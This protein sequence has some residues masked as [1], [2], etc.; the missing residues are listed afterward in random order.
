[1]SLYIKETGSNLNE[2][3]ESIFSQTVMPDEIVVVKD[4]PLSE[5]VEDVLEKYI[6]KDERLFRIISLKQNEGLGRALAKGIMACSYNLIARMD[7]DDICRKDRF[8]KQLKEFENN[9][10]LDIVGSHIYEFEGNISNVLSERKVPILH[11]EICKYQKRRSAFNHMTVMFKKNS[12]L[13][14]G[15][16]QHA[17]L[18]EDDLLWVNMILSGAKCKNIDDFLVYARTGVNMIE[19]RGGWSYFKKYKHGR[20]IIYDTGFISGWDYYS[21]VFV[22]FIVGMLPKKLRLYV[23]IKCLRKN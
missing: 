23:F 22:Q 21:T 14:A 9:P 4:G 13:R 15:N 7:T 1:M 11:E 19:R 6:K 18:M 16:Y 17:L 12:V 2:C 8:E 5:D 10:E 20:K 3:L